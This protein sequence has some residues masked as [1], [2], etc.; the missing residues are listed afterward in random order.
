VGQLAA[1]RV[2]SPAWSS[3][4]GYY[5]P[6]EFIPVDTPEIETPVPRSYRLEQNHPNPFNPTTT[7][8]FALPRESPVR[9]VVLD[10]SG[11]H[12]R[13]LVDGVREAGLHQVPFEAAGLPSGVYWYRLEAQGFA[14]A[15]RLVLLK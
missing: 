4:V 12:V 5:V 7:I 2:A 10:V 15:R 6:G 14:Q 8:R 13:T 1:G 11:R 9:L 3:Q